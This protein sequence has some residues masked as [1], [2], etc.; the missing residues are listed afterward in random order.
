MARAR[1]SGAGA[2]G[3]GLPPSG[4]GLTPLPCQLAEQT[5]IAV[6]SLKGLRRNRRPSGVLL[7]CRRICVGINTMSLD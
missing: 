7:F 2:L 1:V 5:G 3:G 4:R 6:D